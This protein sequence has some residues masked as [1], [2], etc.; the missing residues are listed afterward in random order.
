MRNETELLL[1]RT[2]YSTDQSGTHLTNIELP[3]KPVKPNRRSRGFNKELIEFRAELKALNR[4]TDN[5]PPPE[6]WH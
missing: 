3:K 6:I 4:E 2:G 5:F 1:Y